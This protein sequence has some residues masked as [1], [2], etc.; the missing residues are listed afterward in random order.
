MA[1]QQP[2]RERV[3]AA[4]RAPVKV[5]LP[6]PHTQA[7]ASKASGSADNIRTRADTMPCARDRMRDNRIQSSNTH[8]Y[9]GMWDCTFRNLPRERDL[10][11]RNS[12]STVFRKQLQAAEAES[13]VQSVWVQEQVL[14]QEQELR[15]E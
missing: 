2:R 5:F 6:S 3:P 4:F 15:S 13:E 10:L 7:C 1:G 12:G 11:H 9:S 14:R 8:I